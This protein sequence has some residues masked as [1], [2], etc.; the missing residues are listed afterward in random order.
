MLRKI[1]EWLGH[2]PFL[3]QEK[4]NLQMICVIVSSCV[5]GRITFLSM[6]TLICL[7]SVPVN[8]VS[9]LY[10]QLLCMR[11]QSS[12]MQTQYRICLK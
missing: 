7:F 3:K 1:I 6:T 12:G 8:A 11:L 4:N 10:L 5:L 2:L 9:E